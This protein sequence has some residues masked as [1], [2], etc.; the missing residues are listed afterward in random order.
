MTVQSI[1]PNGRGRP[2]TPLALLES[3]GSKHAKYA[4][5]GVSDPVAPDNPIKRRKAPPELREPGRKEW[6][7]I[8]RQQVGLGAAAWLTASDYAALGVYCAA[9][10]RAVEHNIMHAEWTE[11]REATIERWA[12]AA[13][14]KGDVPEP[15]A[16]DWAYEK[17]LGVE[18]KHTRLMATK[19]RLLLDAI[20]ACSFMPDS[21]LRIASAV[22]RALA[23]D[24]DQPQSK[25]GSG[26]Q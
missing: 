20:R 12:E 23:S 4:G 13:W 5:G 26:L 2:R 10:D 11:K 8:I 17:W 6:N 1:N 7:R 19:Q 14:H 9:F 16:Y 22:A 15:E 3:K 18:A 21:R 24:G 25:F